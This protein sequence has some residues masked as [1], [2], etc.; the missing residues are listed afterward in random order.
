MSVPVEE[1]KGEQVDKPCGLER[2]HTWPCNDQRNKQICVLLS[3][4][5]TV[6]HNICTEMGWT[7]ANNKIS[8]PFNFGNMCE[9]ECGDPTSSICKC[10][11]LRIYIKTIILNEFPTIIEEGAKVVDVITFVDLCFNELLLLSENLDELRETIARHLSGYGGEDLIDLLSNVFAEIKD[12]QIS[13][14]FYPFHIKN[15]FL[16]DDDKEDLELLLKKNLYAIFDDHSPQFLDFLVSN[17]KDT[18]VLDP[19]LI[20]NIQD[21]LCGDKQND[22]DDFM[23]KYLSQNMK[24]SQTPMSAVFSSLEEQVANYEEN[25]DTIIGHAM[26]LKCIFSYGGKMWAFFKNSWGIEVGFNGEHVAPFGVFLDCRIYLPMFLQLDPDELLNK[27]IKLRG[28]LLK[29][30]RENLEKITQIQREL[31][32]GVKERVKEREIEMTKIHEEV[33]RYEEKQ[34]AIQEAEEEAHQQAQANQMDLE[35]VNQQA[36][37]QAQ[38]A[39]VNQQLVNPPLNKKRGHKG[40]DSLVLLK[41]PKTNTG[42]NSSSKKIRRKKSKRNKKQKQKEKKKKTVKRYRRMRKTRTKI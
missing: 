20:Q 26:V 23:S 40:S 1:T 29:R 12:R 24:N 21:I 7:T 4:V 19:S 35:L 39:V 31:E 15:G 18:P 8:S 34:A 30:N 6:A 3:V 36:H 27:K 32:E 38:Q 16:D 22:I 5:N 33:Q 17:S 2:A 11:L 14:T 28:K 42:G 37:L 25:E 10:C 41:D 9:K 13:I